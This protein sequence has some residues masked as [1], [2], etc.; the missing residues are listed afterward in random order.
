MGL[1]RFVINQQILMIPVLV[2][3]KLLNCHSS[4]IKRIK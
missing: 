4:K 3:N 1:S 2:I